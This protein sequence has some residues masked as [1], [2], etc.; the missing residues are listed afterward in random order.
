MP[1]SSS[2]PGISPRPP[3]ELAQAINRSRVLVLSGKGLEATSIS[4][5]PTGVVAWSLETAW[6]GMLWAKREFVGSGTGKNVEW[7]WSK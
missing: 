4:L 2:S 5:S 7:A 1:P 3:G 6:M